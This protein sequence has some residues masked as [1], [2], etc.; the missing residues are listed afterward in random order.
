MRHNYKE[1]HYR[2]MCQW[3]RLLHTAS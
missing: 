2:L 3:L 1:V